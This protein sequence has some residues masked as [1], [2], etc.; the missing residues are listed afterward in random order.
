MRQTIAAAMSRSKREIPHYYLSTT[1]D[2]QRSVLGL[3]GP[4]ST[5]RAD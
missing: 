2:L 5:G 1:I 4:L 3:K